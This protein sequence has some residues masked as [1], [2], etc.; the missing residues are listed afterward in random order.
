MERQKIKRIKIHRGLRRPP[1]DD[2]LCNNQPKTGFRDG[3]GYEGEVCDK[4][5]A[6]GKHYAIVLGALL[7]DRRLKI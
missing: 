7:V 4:R 3:G 6:Q 2:L 5:K 1:I